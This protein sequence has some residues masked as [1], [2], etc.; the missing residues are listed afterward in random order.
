MKITC[1]DCSAS[2]NVNLPN[3]D[4]Q[5]IDVKCA[6]CQSTFTV[7]DEASKAVS[8]A[9]AFG[10]ETADN[11]THQDHYRSKPVQGPRG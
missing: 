4:E 6:R 10:Q 8:A 2:Y 3:L 1:P 5:G 11:P 7:K 9:T